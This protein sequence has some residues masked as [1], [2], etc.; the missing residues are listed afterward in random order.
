RVCPRTR[1]VFGQEEKW[2]APASRGATSSAGA[3]TSTASS[4]TARPPR[5]RLRNPSSGEERSELG[6]VCLSDRASGNAPPCQMRSTGV[7][8]ADGSPSFSSPSSPL[9][10][11]RPPHDDGAMAGRQALLLLA[12][13]I[14]LTLATVLIIGATGRPQP[15]GVGFGLA[16]LAAVVGVIRGITS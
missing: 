14:A 10:E 15:G 11:T 12:A 4:A 1:R 3:R 5:T 2:R 16:A 8:M 9:V 6:S 13:S 7:P